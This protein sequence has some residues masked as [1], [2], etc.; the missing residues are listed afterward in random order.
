MDLVKA[1]SIQSLINA[2]SEGAAK[3]LART[4][5]GELSV[6][7]NS[8]RDELIKILAYTETCIDYADDDLP[9]DILHSSKD[10]LLNSLQKLE[11][12][13]NISNSKKRSYRWI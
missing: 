7:V 9:S 6:F 8:L 10:L 3:I 12:I 13:I 5:N 1:E 11:H 4:M 2:R